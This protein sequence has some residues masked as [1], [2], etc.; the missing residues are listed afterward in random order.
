MELRAP[1][2]LWVS[3]GGSSG[4]TV[5]WNLETFQIEAVL[6]PMPNVPTSAL[7]IDPTGRFALIR[8][9]G[10]TLL[11]D[12]ITLKPIRELGNV[13]AFP[14]L[15]TGASFSPDALLLA[16]F[17][18]LGDG[19]IVAQIRDAGTGEIVRSSTP[20]KQHEPAPVACHLGQKE[21]R[22]LHSDG[23]LTR[24]P[25]DPTRAAESTHMEDA[26]VTLNH[27]V[28]SST[29]NSV[30]VA[31]DLGAYD[32]PRLA[33][34][35]YGEENAASL[36]ADLLRQRFPWSRQP[37]LWTGLMRDT[38][39]PSLRLLDET[40]LSPSAHTSPLI[41]EAELTCAAFHNEWLL[42]GDS[43][44]TVMIHRYLA[45]PPEEASMS[46]TAQAI[47]NPPAARDIPPDALNELRERLARQQPV[48]QK[49]YKALRTIFDKAE[50]KAVLGAIKKAGGSGAL[51]ATCLEL[52]LASNKPH[53]IRACLAA[54][55]DMPPLLR[56]LARSR[57][58]WLEDKKAEAII[59]WPDEF[60]SLAEVRKREDWDG[61]EQAN[62][63]HAMEQFRLCMKQ[64]LDAIQVPP[65][66]SPAQL[67]ELTTRLFDPATLRAVGDKR[68]A[69][70]CLDAAMALSDTP[71]Q[72]TNTL[73]LAT[74]ARQYGSPPELC[75]RAEALSFTAL[76][77]YEKARERWVRLITEYPV[78]NHLPGDYAEAAYTSFENADPVQAMAILATGMHRFPN[79]ANFALRAGWVSLLT[80]N[81]ERAYRFLTT[82]HRIGYPAE[83]AE[84]ALLLLA[85]AAVQTSAVDDA[86]MYYDELIRLDEDWRDPNTIETLEWP[87]ELKAS[88]RQ[89][90]W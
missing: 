13:P 7:V 21:L 70:A 2:S 3:V 8:R 39:D 27:A 30:L 71:E 5:R 83:K 65:D 82:G 20:M 41:T 14:C 75:L 86:M 1:A 63:S 84:N 77:D 88:L 22:V 69:K 17:E 18:T 54:A 52:A 40:T 9:A 38:A 68:Y 58:A 56:R 72:S 79:D 33:V 26:S 25:I 51:A 45:P 34:L 60:P 90:A 16:Y 50:D 74:L 10:I 81:A 32:T 43:Q 15:Q 57:I 44:G 47:V 85:I 36:E 73:R 28:F 31:Q 35:S 87:E 24:L 49:H 6:F 55:E 42:S 19:A 62:F 46:R 11:C 67:D 53:R 64:E 4:S 66:A 37:S 12:A 89:L 61:W 23:T 59:G 80:G 48:S 29:G 76:G 78:E